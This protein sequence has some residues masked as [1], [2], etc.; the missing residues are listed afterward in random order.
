MEKLQEQ[1]DEAVLGFDSADDADLKQAMRTF[2]ES[3]ART[4]AHA[5]HS[6]ANA[7]YWFERELRQ[8]LGRAVVDLPGGHVGFV[9]APAEFARELLATLGPGPRRV[10]G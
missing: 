5:P 7:T 8:Y 2:P 1:L 6:P 4:M 10:L 3:D 9:S